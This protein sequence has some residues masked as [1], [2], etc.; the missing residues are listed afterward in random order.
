MAVAAVAH[1]LG[2]RAGRERY[3]QIRTHAERL[4]RDPRVQEKTSQA[5]DLVKAKAPEARE[6]RSDAAKHAAAKAESHKA[7][8]GGITGANPP[9]VSR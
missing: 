7:Q 4:W 3:E 9:G 6:H 8:D 2:A 5:A 1:V